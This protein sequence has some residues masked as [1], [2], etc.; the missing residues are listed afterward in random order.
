MSNAEPRTT[1]RQRG[2]SNRVYPSRPIL[3]V[4]AVIIVDDA[5]VLVRRAREPLRGRWSLPGGAVELGET[6][7]AAVAREVREETGLSVEVGSI[8]DAVDHIECDADGRPIYHFVITDFL[9]TSRGGD[10]RAGDDVDGAALV[11]AATL[12]DYQ[13]TPLTA[14]VIE[15]AFELYTALR[16]SP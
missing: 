12:G 9:C 5:V 15:K 14:A 6:L 3:G 10:L 1:G 8:V 16:R 11:R 2:T 13:V 4:G 7:R